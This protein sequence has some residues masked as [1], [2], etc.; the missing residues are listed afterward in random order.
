MSTR[1]M[2]TII[3]LNV[4]IYHKPSGRALCCGQPMLCLTL[5]M[6]CTVQPEGLPTLSRIMYVSFHLHATEEGPW[7]HCADF[8]PLSS[9]PSFFCFP[10]LPPFFPQTHMSWQ[11]NWVSLSLVTLTAWTSS[12]GAM[13]MKF[14]WRGIFKFISVWSER[15][16]V[17]SVKRE[18]K[19]WN[20]RRE[21]KRVECERESYERVE[22]VECERGV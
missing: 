5:V 6:G 11:M 2:L 14:Y 8:T 7:H 19:K 22:C 16:W 1:V 20:I 9:L 15:V 21:C 18:A 12:S 3:V 13:E 4:D 17:M 10:V